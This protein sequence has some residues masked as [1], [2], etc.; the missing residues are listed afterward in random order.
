MPTVC[1]VVNPQD[2]EPYGGLFNFAVAAAAAAAAAAGG[3]GVGRGRACFPAGVLTRA[4]V[5]PCGERGLRGLARAV[6]RG[7]HM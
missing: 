2:R 5:S 4:R 1:T 7:G 6:G 3:M